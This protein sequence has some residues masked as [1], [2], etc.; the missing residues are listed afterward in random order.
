MARRKVVDEK[1]LSQISKT[2]SKSIPNSSDHARTNQIEAWMY[3]LKI[4]KAKDFF[5]E[6]E[7]NDLFRK[8]SLN[9]I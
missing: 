2:D 3:I 1:S 6:N 4:V 9:T 7:E 5:E 8:K